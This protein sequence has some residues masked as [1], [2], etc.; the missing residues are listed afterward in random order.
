MAWFSVVFSSNPLY[1]WHDVWINC[2]AIVAFQA[3]QTV[4]RVAKVTPRKV[5]KHYF[6]CAHWSRDHPCS[7]WEQNLWIQELTSCKKPVR[8]SGWVVFSLQMIPTYRLFFMIPW[9]YHV[10]LHT[11]VD[12]SFGRGFSTFTILFAILPPHN[13]GSKFQEFQRA[14]GIRI[15][16]EL[17]T[18]PR[19]LHQ[20]E[21]WMLH[22]HEPDA[23]V[24]DL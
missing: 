3:S 22:S 10:F 8:N 12:G 6:A 4:V 2:C 5:R 11:L 21:G 7:F 18:V 14:L 16:A 24:K 19:I 20:L 15:L 1:D 17:P 13:C 23:F 9:W